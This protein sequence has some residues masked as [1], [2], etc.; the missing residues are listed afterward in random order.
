MSSA[1][2]RFHYLLLLFSAVLLCGCGSHVLR[3]VSSEQARHE[4]EYVAAV[5]QK[6]YVDEAP[7]ARL[8]E[9]AVAGMYRYAGVEPPPHSAATQLPEP[10]L[11]RFSQVY[12]SLLQH[13]PPQRL[14][15]APQG[16]GSEQ[17]VATAGQVDIGLLLVKNDEWIRIAA[18]AID[19]A[20][21]AAGL[22]RGDAII[23]IDGH[24]T[25][26]MSLSWCYQQ[27]RGAEGTVVEVSVNSEAGAVVDYRIVRARVRTPHV[28]ML[29]LPKP[30]Y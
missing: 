19:S 22:N 28:V 11:A 20:A 27:L 10:P 6:N 18:V 17:Q 30:G 24:A 2:P 4:F 8:V 3:P 25:A 15:A 14:T 16:D 1:V 5:V 23:A 7:L 21:E 29:R 26:G 12:D 13:Q 9:G